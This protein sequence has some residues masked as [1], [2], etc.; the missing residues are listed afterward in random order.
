M[1]SLPYRSA[2]R[3]RVPNARL[4]HRT[5]FTCCAPC[6]AVAPRVL[7]LGGKKCV[8]ARQTG[9]LFGRAQRS[10]LDTSMVLGMRLP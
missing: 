5:R 7:G 1:R 8:D 9:R 3:G 4:R 10:R 2:I 6:G